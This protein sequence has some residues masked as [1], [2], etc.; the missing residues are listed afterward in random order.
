[1]AELRAS[2]VGAWLTQRL[3]QARFVATGSHLA[4]LVGQWRDS[5]DANALARLRQR[6]LELTQAFD[7]AD[8]L[9]LDEAGNLVDTRDGSRP[10]TPTEL[11]AART[12][13]RPSRTGRGAR[14]RRRR[15][16][17]VA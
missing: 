12:A 10:T 16:E 6:L 3:A 17:P 15:G 8:T 5:G 7:L 2:Q 9:L 1:M 13:Q 4:D 11:H 14:R